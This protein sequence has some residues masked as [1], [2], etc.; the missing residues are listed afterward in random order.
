MGKIK[1][2]NNLL[3]VVDFKIWK[4]LQTEGILPHFYSFRW[5]SLMLAQ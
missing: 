2:L 1:L 4:K 5:L 3:K